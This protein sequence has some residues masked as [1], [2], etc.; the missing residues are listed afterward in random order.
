M[1]KID[2]SHM[3]PILKKARLDA[4]LTQEELGGRIG[5]TARYLQAVENEGKCVSLNTFMR[6][7]RSLNISADEIVYP[8]LKSNTDETVQLLRIIK[9]LNGRDRKVLLATV[10]EML[11]NQ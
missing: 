1:D 8:E 7:I 6:L 9:L 10:M 2:L 11:E 3:G 5:K 4:R